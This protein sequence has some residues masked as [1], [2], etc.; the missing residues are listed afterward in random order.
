MTNC[1]K[2]K[3]EADKGATLNSPNFYEIEE[4]TPENTT[5][6]DIEAGILNGTYTPVDPDLYTYQGSIRADY[7]KEVMHVLSLQ[8]KEITINGT[9]SNGGVNMY[10]VVYFRVVPNITSAWDNRS[11]EL[12]FDIKRTEKADTDNVDIWVK[13]TIQVNAVVTE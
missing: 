3:L 8:T 2:I 6:A 13:G 4:I 11:M 7:N 10:K 1:I 12:L 9:V 5:I